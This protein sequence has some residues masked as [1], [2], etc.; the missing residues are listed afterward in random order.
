MKFG[1]YTAKFNETATIEFDPIKDVEAD[2]LV[3]MSTYL[4]PDNTGC[5]WEAKI[6]FDSSPIG[7][8][9]DNLEWQPIANYQDLELFDLAKEVKLRAT[10]KSNKYIS[11][12]MSV[13]D[14]T[15]TTFL[16]ELSGAYIGRGIDMTEAP[17]NHIRFSYEAFLPKGAKVI[18]KYSVD[19][20]STWKTF[21]TQPK[22]ITANNEFVRYTYDEK[23]NSSSTYKKLK[24]RLDLSTENSFLRPSVRR[25]MVTTRDE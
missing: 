5:L 21:T 9:F 20:G 12:L 7:T 4:T 15:F 17:Y 2:R 23:V 8:T 16:T 13:S 18:P 14:L 6:I 19:E 3:L 24:V 10:F 25:L 11:P 22:T 1:I